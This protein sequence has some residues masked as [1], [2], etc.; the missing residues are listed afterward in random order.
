MAMMGKVMSAFP[1]PPW[2]YVPPMRTVGLGAAGV[3]DHVGAVAQ[4][5]CLLE[6]RGIVLGRDLLRRVRVRRAKR[7]GK[8]ELGLDNVDADHLGR[9][10][11]PGD[12]GAE[13]ADGASAH[14]DDGA[15]RPH[16]ALPDNVHGDGERLN[17][18]ALLQR[19]L[20]GQLV[21]KVGRRRPQT[22]QRAVVR[23]RRG[24]NHLGAQIVLARAAVLAASAAVAG[25]EGDAVAGLEIRDGGAY[26]DDGAGGLVAEDHGLP[27]DKV[28]DGA[29]HVVVH[30]APADAS[31]VDGYQHIV[32]VL[33]GGLGLLDVGHIKRLVEDKGQLGRPS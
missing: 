16:V 8:V 33:N 18:R 17:Q 10:V 25:L 19:D 24:E 28:A 11:R 2:T 7:L 31:V 26:L 20:V 13:E 9:A 21:A 32:R 30:V 29:V 23:R 6:R 3:N 4:A 1:M 27:D 22:R 14:D 5:G 15:A 12:G